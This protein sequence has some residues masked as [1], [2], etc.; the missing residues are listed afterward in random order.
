MRTFTLIVAMLIAIP[1]AAFA[2]TVTYYSPQTNL[3]TIDLHW[4]G[5]A[6]NSPDK[7]LYVA[8]YSFTDKPLARELIHLAR[9]GVKVYVYRDDRQMKDRTDITWMLQNVPGIQIRAKDDKGFWNIMH[10]KL[11]IIPGVVFRE[12]SANWSPSAEGASD[13]RGNS[14]HDEQQDNN[15]TYITA[16]D[17]IRQAVQ[18]FTHIWDRI[19]NIRY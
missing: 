3:Q 7:V 15:A 17:E 18:Q 14:G 11:F 13:Y 12:G 8:M 4:L 10:N 19:G 5:M 1:A 6:Q 9:H 16:P 2:K